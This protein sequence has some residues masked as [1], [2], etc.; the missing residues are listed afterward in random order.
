MVATSKS[1]IP[2]RISTSSGVRR[3]MKMEKPRTRTPARILAT[4][5]ATLTASFLCLQLVACDPVN[6][7][8]SYPELVDD[9]VRVELINYRN[10]EAKT[11]NTF[12]SQREL[13]TRFD[14]SKMEVLETLDEEM[15]DGFFSELSSIWLWNHWV[16]LDSPLG[17]SVRLVYSNGDFEVI[18]C[19]FGNGVEGGLI[20]RY[21]SSGKLLKNIGLVKYSYEFDI[22]LNA[23]FET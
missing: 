12:F 15:M 20:V 8:Y 9:V 13:Q 18:S 1:A 14:F 19:C 10:P 3:A 23:F 16:H 2:L 4:I 21:D 22:L 17:R 11:I 6:T 7:S 5:L